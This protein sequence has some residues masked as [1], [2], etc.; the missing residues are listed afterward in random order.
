MQQLIRDPLRGFLVENLVVLELVKTRLNKGLEP[1]L[2]FYRDN[3]NNEVDI[4]YKQ[5]NDLVPIEIK[6]SQTYHADF[7]KSI[8][9]YE[10][11]ANSRVKNGYLVYAGKHEQQ[12]GNIEIINF[13]HAHKIVS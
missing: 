7:L 13:K 5:S 10:S 6:A 12:I 4:I 1:N 2:Y 8:K 3:H 9:F 11:I